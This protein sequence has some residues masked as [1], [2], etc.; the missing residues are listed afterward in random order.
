VRREETVR[1]GETKAITLAFSATPV[2]LPGPPQPPEQAVPGPVKIGGGV[3]VAG[4]V[5]AV[6]GAA[7]MPSFGA[8]YAIAQSKYDT[9]KSACGDARCTDPRYAGVVDTGKRMELA[10]NVSLVAGA[11]GLGVG[12]AMIIF[13]GPSVKPSAKAGA[14][15]GASIVFS[16][17]GIRIGRA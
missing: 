15:S 1:A 11:V 6:L 3:R 5:I 14:P 7:G 13:G 10:S 4:I 17:D 16:P 2:S 9:L 12:G 8:T